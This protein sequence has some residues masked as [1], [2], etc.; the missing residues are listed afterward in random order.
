MT[1][2]GGSCRAEEKNFQRVV[3]RKMLLFPPEMLSLAKSLV[4]CEDT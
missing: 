4:H 3:S 1:R 2:F